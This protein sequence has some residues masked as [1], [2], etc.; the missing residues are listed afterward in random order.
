MG[1]VRLDESKYQL[2]EL[3]VRYIHIKRKL[4]LY[5]DSTRNVVSTVERRLC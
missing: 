2:L 4:V 5:N 3:R 1:G